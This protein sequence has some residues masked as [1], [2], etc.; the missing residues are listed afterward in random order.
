M[1]QQFIELLEGSGFC[2]LDLPNEGTIR[3]YQAQRQGGLRQGDYDH[4]RAPNVLDGGSPRIGH[5]R[6]G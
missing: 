2:V 4:R 6:R 1:I 3:G 5:C